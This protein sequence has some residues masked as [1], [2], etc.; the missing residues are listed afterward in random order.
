[1]PFA[2]TWM[3]LGNVILSKT[4]KDISYNITQTWNLIFLNDIN[5]LVYKT[6]IDFWI[7]KTSLWL[8]L[9]KCWGRD[10]LGARDRHT[11]LACLTPCD[12]I[13]CSSSDSSVH[14]IFQLKIL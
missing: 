13:D 5:G 1:M 8:P 4:E 12:S 3:D 7:S 6:E 11:Q 10:T 9:Q 2:A 14:G